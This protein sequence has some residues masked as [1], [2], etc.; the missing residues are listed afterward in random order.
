MLGL[1]ASELAVDWVGMLRE[2]E[3]ERVERVHRRGMQARISVKRMKLVLR[4]WRHAAS[5]L[6]PREE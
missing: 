6:N 5:T 4:F 1:Q 3:C 2:M